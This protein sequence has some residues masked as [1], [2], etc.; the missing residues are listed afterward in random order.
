LTSFAELLNSTAARFPSKEPPVAIAIENLWWPGLT[1]VDHTETQM[2]IEQLN[3]DNWCFVLD[4]GH[5]LNTN[6]K[7]KSEMESIHFLDENLK[8]F[9]EEIINKID[10][11]HLS[12]SNTGKYQAQSIAGG[13]PTDFASLSFGDKYI[14]ARD[15]AS[16][17]DQHLPFSSPEINQILDQINPRYIVHEFLGSLEKKRLSIQQQKG[18]LG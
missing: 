2:F 17:I 9:P 16:R 6:W 3:F 12:Y 8:K 1:F 5:L 13:L 14:L 18:L 10:V 11:L 7:R 15:H 4:T